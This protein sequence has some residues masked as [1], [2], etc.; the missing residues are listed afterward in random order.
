MW[1][2]DHHHHHH[3]C[4]HM[5]SEVCL[6]TK[7]EVLSVNLKHFNLTFRVNGFF[8]CLFFIYFNHIFNS[9]LLFLV[10]RGGQ[11]VEVKT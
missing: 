11:T 2:I 8:Y 5:V 9:F 6:D 10:G 3:H 4:V 7:F 1:S